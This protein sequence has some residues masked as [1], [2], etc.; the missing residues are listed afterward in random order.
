MSDIKKINTSK[1]I[2][3]GK[4]EVDGKIWDVVLPGAGTELKM[5]K[6]QR[7]A[8]FLAKK[9]ES[10]TATEEDLD[11]LDNIE[12]EYLN[13]FKNIFRDATKDN[14]EVSEWVEKTPTAVIMQAIEDIREQANENDA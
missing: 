7:R 13:L 11:R 3:E 9:V 12:D 8:D 6:M 14:S 1:Y 5:G 10:G 2:T 4:V